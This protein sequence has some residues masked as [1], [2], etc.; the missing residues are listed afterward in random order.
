MGGGSPQVLGR[1]F[2][3]ASPKAFGKPSGQVSP[4]H[5]GRVSGKAFASL[6]GKVS[7]EASAKISG[8]DFPPLLG[9]VSGKVSPKLIGTFTAKT[10]GKASPK[11]FGR[12]FGNASTK[13]FPP[14]YRKTLVRFG[15]NTGTRAISSPRGRGTGREVLDGTA[16]RWTCT[17]ASEAVGDEDETTGRARGGRLRSESDGGAGPL[18]GRET[19]E[20]S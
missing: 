12:F 19:T 4:K 13:I 3:K 18:G 8:R 17:K 9:R 10:S 6:S 7:R 5:I 2:A 15:T 1:L 14:L 16:P 11:A 20:E